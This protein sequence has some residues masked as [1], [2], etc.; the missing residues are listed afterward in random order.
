MSQ[1]RMY[2][3]AFLNIEQDIVQKMD[4]TDIIGL[5]TAVKPRKRL[6]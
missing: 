1:E 5:F 2:N 6:F 4:F 3:L